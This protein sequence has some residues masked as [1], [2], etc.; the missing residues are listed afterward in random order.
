MNTLNTK[1]NTEGDTW[2][3][4]LYNLYNTT[5]SSSVLEV[6]I[7]SMIALLGGGILGEGMLLYVTYIT[8]LILQ[9][10]NFDFTQVFDVNALQEKFNLI[11]D[12][13]SNTVDKIRNFIETP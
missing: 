1:G 4:T 12:W 5:Q 11:K 10:V 7:T 2:G 9:D 3:D 8:F 13:G 6:T